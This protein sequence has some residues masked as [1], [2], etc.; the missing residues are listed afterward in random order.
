[1]QLE[2]KKK[3]KREVT[4]PRSHLPKGSCRAWIQTQASPAPGQAIL[5]SFQLPASCPAAMRS[6]KVVV[7]SRWLVLV[8]VMD[9]IPLGNLI[10]SLHNLGKTESD[11][12]NIFF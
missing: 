7:G 11:Q 9:G 4:F 1:M 10:F 3:A 2:K 6:L 12:K 5:P 8:P